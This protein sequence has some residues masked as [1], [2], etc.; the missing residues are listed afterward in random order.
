MRSWR[1]MSLPFRIGDS[2]E[3]D[4]REIGDEPR[5]AEFVGERGTVRTMGISWIGVAF[6]RCVHSLV[7]SND[8]VKRVINEGG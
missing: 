1:T 5:L 3:L 8:K 7:I 4:E 2:V 6:E